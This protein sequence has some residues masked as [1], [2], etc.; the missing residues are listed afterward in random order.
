MRWHWVD[1]LEEC[2][3]GKSA[4]GIKDFSAVEPFFMDHFP[5]RPMVPGVL[6]IEMIAQTAG[7]C[8]RI[9]RPEVQPILVSVRSARFLRPIGPGDSCRINVKIVKLGSRYAHETGFIEV[10]DTRVAEADLFMA[11]VPSFLRD[12]EMPVGDPERD[13][14]H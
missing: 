11:I 6:E 4:V 1:R 7:R 13:S 10:S 2:K 12:G 14:D 9:L 8:I 3:P 5:G